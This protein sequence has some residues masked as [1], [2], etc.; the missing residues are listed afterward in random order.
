[1]SNYTVIH[2]ITL[3]LRRR[4]H[5]ALSSASDADLGMTTPETDITLSPPGEG[6]QGQP[7]LSLYLY[8]VGPDAHLR[9]QHELAVGQS[10]LRPPPLAVQLRYLI[11]P[12]D[13]EEQ[14]NH[15]MLGRVLQ[16]FHDQP[17]V[18][19][20]GNDLL[21]DSFGGSSPQLRVNIEP[22]S[23][24]Q[25]GPIWLAL[26]ASYRLSVAYAVRVV[27][28]DSDRGV[29]EAHRVVEALAAVGR[30]TDGEIT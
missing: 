27:A 14:H 3:E 6:L 30:K 7:R 19:A 4:I 17:F 21:G 15:L 24:D 16:H 25:L 23:M 13:D 5:A 11:T 22:L 2:D 28:I 9:N 20:L 29:T 10:G 8:H 26:Q 18:S 12:L 1:M